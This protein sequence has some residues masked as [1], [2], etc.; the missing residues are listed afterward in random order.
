MNIFKRIFGAHKNT[1]ITEEHNNQ[2]QV[3]RKNNYRTYNS[4]ISIESKQI[5]S[6]GTT[7]NA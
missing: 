6:L 1:S 7:K 5:S 3:K 2:S 4:K